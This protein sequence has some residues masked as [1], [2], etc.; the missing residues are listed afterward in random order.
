[1]RHPL[2]IRVPR[3]SQ[4]HP[5]SAASSNAMRGNRAQDTQ[6]EIMLRRALWMMGARYRKNVTRLPGKPDLVFHKARVAVFCDG[7]FWHGRKWKSLRHKLED[8]A[9]ASYWVKKIEANR[10]RD[11][12]TT[13]RLRRA[14]WRVIRVW[15]GD[16]RHDPS[17]VAAKILAACTRP[18][19]EH[20]TGLPVCRMARHPATGRVVR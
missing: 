10:R 17:A 12:R 4:F 13:A 20:R 7:D 19:N 3:Y 18:M 1:M 14:G 16:V 6:P 8:R 9:N 2:S 5:A 11:R 15:E